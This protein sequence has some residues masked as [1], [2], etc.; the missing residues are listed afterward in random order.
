MT[1]AEPKKRVLFV[2]RENRVRSRTAEQVYRGRPDLEVRSAGIAEYAA[3][4][5]TAEL[6]DWADLVF[7]FSKYHQRIVQARFG[8]QADGKPL[9]CL[10]VPDR[11]DYKCPKLVARLVEGVCPYLGPPTADRWASTENRVSPTVDKADKSWSLLPDGGSGSPFRD[12]FG[13]F[14]SWLSSAEKASQAEVSVP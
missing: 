14:R 7:V 5:L 13:F 10:R 11:F 3:T 4:P 8:N 2:C 12:L 1:A 6:V 9:V